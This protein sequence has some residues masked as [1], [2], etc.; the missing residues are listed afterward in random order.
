M[1]IA[2]SQEGR[3]L[4]TGVFGKFVSW[5]W[6]LGGLA[7]LFVGLIWLHRAGGQMRRL[8][9]FSFTPVLISWLV[10]IGTI[11]DHRFRLPTLGLSLF[12]QVAGYFALKN[13]FKTEKI[14]PAF[15]QTA[16]PR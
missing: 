1:N 13:R 2:K 5:I 12:L 8:A 16:R 9:W 10:S 7:F 4:V 11:G 3:Q 14:A 6:L 15:E